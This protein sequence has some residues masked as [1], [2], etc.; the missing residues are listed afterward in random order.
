MGCAFAPPC[1]AA[2]SEPELTRE[3][4]AFFERR[5]RPVLA[6]K[7]YSCHG[8]SK[9]EGELRLDTA[10]GLSRGGESGLV[11]I[12]GDPAKSRLIQII[13]RAHGGRAMPPKVA[14]SPSAVADF[15]TWVQMG[16]PDPRGAASAKPADTPSPHWAFQ[17][18]RNP[19]APRVTDPA[20]VKDPIDAFVLGGLEQ[21]GLRPAPPAD[22]PALIRRLS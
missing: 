3:G 18:L 13:R 12:P 19:I 21:H 2:A 10:E 15:E 5:I 22:R 17:P 7:C 16:A 20:W 4:V 1:R 6:S 11:V 9:R 8:S 14:L